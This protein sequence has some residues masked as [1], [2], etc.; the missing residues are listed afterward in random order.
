MYHFGN[1][2]LVSI[3]EETE[4]SK[5]AS[6]TGKK[7]KNWKLQKHRIGTKFEIKYLKKK[8][9]SNNKCKHVYDKI[10]GYKDLAPGNQFFQIL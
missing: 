5:K 6:D 8:E 1:Q 4:P 9:H 10:N 3:E 2:S 7:V